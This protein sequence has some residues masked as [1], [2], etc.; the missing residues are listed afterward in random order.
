[1]NY[2]ADEDE[3]KSI[4]KNQ[5]ST[6]AQGSVDGRKG[7]LNNKKI[8]SLDFV[9]NSVIGHLGIDFRNACAMHNFT[10]KP[11]LYDKGHT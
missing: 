9:R 10:F 3:P 1:L 4:G 2:D 6:C 11:I 7:I 5:A 8:K